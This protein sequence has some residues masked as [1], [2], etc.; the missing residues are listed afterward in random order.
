M[1]TRASHDYYELLGV[2]RTATPD[3]IKKA[4]RRLAVRYH[5]DKNPDNK[6]AEEKFKE[7]STAYAVLSD[8]DKRRKY[9]QFGHAAFE[10]SGGGGFT[11]VDLHDLLRT[12]F[13]GFGGSG[14][15]SIFDDFFG[16]GGG[17]GQ[18]V[19]RGND[20]R[21]T[22][23]LDFE[24]SAK[25]TEVDIKL[26][27]LE[28]C[29]TCA[30]TG[31]KAGA[32][33]KTCGACGGR[34]QV[35]RAQQTLFGTFASVTTCPKCQGTGKSVG[36]PC[37]DCHGEGRET[38]RRTIN[39]KIPAGI[40]DGMVIRMRGEGDVGPFNGP[41]GDLHVVVHVKPHEVFE[42]RELDLICR[43]PVKYTQLVL[44]AEIAVPTLR[45]DRQGKSQKTVIRIPPGTDTH[46]IF[47]VRGFGMPDVHSDRSGDLL[48]QVEIEIPR[49]LSKREK[50]I[51]TELS[52]SANEGNVKVKGFLD[53]LTDLIS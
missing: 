45:R 31:G 16:G 6:E 2:A 5:P 15:G 20:L 22:V 23:T 53:K 47:R 30:G 10:Q 8:S 26:S 38:V 4:Y 39:V 37:T 7:I 43:V 51:L 27:R 25:E 18:T 19:L 49:K 50:E 35:Q 1:S 41:T 46:T 44:G 3:E 29:G 12:A 13:G 14:G 34:G 40:E 9:D 24:D 36:D 28:A 42:R 21:T 17:R 32:A 52:E 11:Q 33:P 48:V